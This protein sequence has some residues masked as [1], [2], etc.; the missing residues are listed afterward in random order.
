MKIEIYN[1]TKI[2]GDFA[3]LDQVTVSLKEGMNGLL[4]ANGAG[5]TTLMKILVGVLD[6]TYGEIKIDGVDMKNRR[7]LRKNI[8]YIPQK[9]S[10]YPNMSVF[11]IMDYFCALNGIKNKR[12][13]VICNILENVH[14]SEYQTL[15]IRELSGGMVQRLGIAVSLVK[16]PK[17]IVLDEPTVGLDP[18]ERRHF[19][20]IISSIARGRIILL[21]S[22]IVSDIEETCKD[23]IILNHGK[24]IYKGE[25]NKLIEE[26][27][28]NLCA[29]GEQDN[30]F[31]LNLTDAYVYKIDMDEDSIY[32]N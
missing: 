32:E 4:G 8:G 20:H 26:C 21:S 15:K 3:A 1:L 28:N 19:N 18:K 17:I 27:K 13:E 30:T 29:K 2:Y 6:K 31:I 25:K 5:K 9:F 16:D 24:V 11:E 12:K 23:I 10:F 22:H 14:L 7:T